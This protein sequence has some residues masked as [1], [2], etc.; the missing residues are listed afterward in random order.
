MNRNWKYRFVIEYIRE[1]LEQ[2]APGVRC[3]CAPATGT[4]IR[5][6]LDAFSADKE[7]AV[8][9]Y[10]QY[11][12]P[13]Y[14]G[15]ELEK[16]GLYNTS[17]REKDALFNSSSEN[18][19]EDIADFLTDLLMESDD[20]AQSEREKVNDVEKKRCAQ[21]ASKPS[22]AYGGTESLSSDAN[23]SPPAQPA[24]EA[25]PGRVYVIKLDNSALYDLDCV[26]IAVTSGIYRL[27]V[28]HERRIL[29]EDVFDSLT[30]AKETFLSQYSN[31]T[32]NARFEPDWSDGDS[33]DNN[34]DTES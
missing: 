4:L 30:V 5:S 33:N 25:V 7:G 18:L 21:P 3:D 23:P 16:A 17:V 10:K 9:Y 12:A 14:L 22:V 19:P 32:L 29:F 8:E 11:F 31:G 13:F 20:D 27:V 2:L 24:S 6:F 15:L 1:Y 28:V 26:F 34:D